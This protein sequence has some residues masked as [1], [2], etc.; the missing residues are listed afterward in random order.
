MIIER[1]IKSIIK[2][3]IS[4]WMNLVMGLFAVVIGTRI[5]TPD[6]YGVLNVF[7]T[8]SGVLVGISCLGF[9]GGILRFFHEP[10][11]GWDVKKLFVHCLLMGMAGLTILTIGML[12]FYDLITSRIFH[13]VSFYIAV[14]L[15]VN[16]FSIMVLNHFTCQ[17]YRM[18]EDAYHYNIQQVLVQFF[19]KVFV[20]GA[21]VIEPSVE[22]VL[23]MNT[24]GIFL[25]M[26]IYLWIQRKD[27]FPNT[28]SFAWSE[29]FPIAKFSFYSWPKTIIV[30]LDGFLLPLMITTVLGSYYLG[31][32]ASAGYFS[33]MLTVLQNGFRVYWA[34]FIYKHYKDERS[35]I[36]AVHDYILMS[37]IL[38]LGLFIIFQHIVYFMI[39][40]AFHESRLFFSLVVLDPLLMLLMQT[41]C[42]GTTLVKKNQQEA[43]VFV[44]TLMFSVVLIYYLT[45]FYGLIGSAI[46]VAISSLL[47]FSLSTWRGQV[48]YKTI[49]SYKKT[50]FGVLILIVMSVSNV[51]FNNYYYVEML[52]I[53]LLFAVGGGVYRD[54]ISEVVS[55]ARCKLLKS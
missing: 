50:F 37:V 46:A 44:S 16:A 6:V 14:L 41:T 3:S 35:L 24:I 42:Y 4:A 45:C 55:Y 1:F 28:F 32:Y 12:F 48:Y 19:T 11:K 40:Q 7:N 39:G 26:I 43:V 15:S 17:L 36:C 22:V 20:L 31:I 8:S 10:P 9:D 21:A 23:A 52:V 18:A 34:A 5:F 33:A 13:K 51:V 49:S 30:Y 38:L 27:I 47:R 54:R 2:F 53:G 25:L 29:F